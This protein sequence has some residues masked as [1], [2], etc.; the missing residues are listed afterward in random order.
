MPSS[1][2]SA[3]ALLILVPLLPVLQG[4]GCRTH[5]S[6]HVHGQVVEGAGD[7]MLVIYRTRGEGTRT[8]TDDWEPCMREPSWQTLRP[9]DAAASPAPAP[10][11]FDGCTA[12][13]GVDYQADF[14]AF[15]DANG[16]GKLGPGERYGVYPKNPLAREREAEAL[17]LEIRIDRAMP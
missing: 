5:Y 9:C 2:S 11:A 6:A 15:V 1:R 14:A 7:R 12:M 8:C 16:D 13:I 10:G 17:P 4:A 3:V